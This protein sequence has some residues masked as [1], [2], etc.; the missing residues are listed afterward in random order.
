MT[1]PIKALRELLPRIQGICT[2]EEAGRWCLGFVFTHGEALLKRL[3]SLHGFAAD[4]M[5][6]WPDGDVDGGYLQDTAVKHGLLRPE[7]R[8]A[9]C[10]ENGCKCREDY[11]FTEGD[12][13]DCYRHTDLL[14]PEPPHD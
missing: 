9:P 8:T 7:Q 6:C 13:W 12:E 10:A 11:G 3:E 4:I 5:G 14:K 1:D 2:N